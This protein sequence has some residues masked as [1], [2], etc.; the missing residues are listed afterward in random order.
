MFA[1]R[2]DVTLRWVLFL[3]ARG[4]KRRRGWGI[5]AQSLAGRRG[6]GATI[7][8][9]ETGWLGREESLKRACG[10]HFIR[11]RAVVYFFKHICVFICTSRFAEYKSQRRNNFFFFF[12][13]ASQLKEYIY[14]GLH[15]FHESSRRR[16]AAPP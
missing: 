16:A 15:Q 8:R 6:H 5:V 13:L 11:R 4:R 10:E 2:D 3:E 1:A 14:L 7:W 9:G 12:F